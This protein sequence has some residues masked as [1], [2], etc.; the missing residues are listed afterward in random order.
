MFVDFRTELLEGS[1]KRVCTDMEQEVT[2]K[3]KV[4]DVQETAKVDN[5]QEA[6]KIKELMK[7]V[8]NEDEV[9]I[10]VIP[11]AVKPLSI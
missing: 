10:D 3:Q 1:S 6:D 4:D 8:S 9:S 7:I 5:D 11:L 2:K